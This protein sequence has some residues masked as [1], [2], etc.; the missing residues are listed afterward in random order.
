MESP[1]DC[2]D[3]DEVW[4]DLHPAIR[5]LKTVC[6]CNNIKYKTIERAIEQGAR[7]ISQVAARTAATTGQCGGSCTPRV[8]TMIEAHASRQAAT[9]APPDREEDAWWVRKPLGGKS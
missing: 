7:S 8:Q 4:D 1:V 5:E 2:L 6:S 3:N 9:P